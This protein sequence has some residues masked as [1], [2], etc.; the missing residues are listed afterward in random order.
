VNL[1]G[2]NDEFGQGYRLEKYS[3]D[4]AEDCHRSRHSYMKRETRQS[5]NR[6]RHHRHEPK[7]IHHE[8]FRPANPREYLPFDEYKP[9][10]ISDQARESSNNRRRAQTNVE[11][12][13]YIQNKSDDE[14]IRSSRTRERRGF[15][16]YLRP[17]L[18]QT[19][20]SALVTR[21]STDTDEPLIRRKHHHRHHSKSSKRYI[22]DR[23]TERNDDGSKYSHYSRD[24]SGDKRSKDV[25]Q[26]MRV[27]TEMDADTKAVIH[28]PHESDHELD[29][30]P[31]KTGLEISSKREKSAPLIENDKTR[32]YVEIRIPS[33]DGTQKT[34]MLPLSK[35]GPRNFEVDGKTFV[36]TPNQKVDPRGKKHHRSRSSKRL[37]SAMFR[38]WMTMDRPTRRRASSS[39]SGSAGSNEQISVVNGPEGKFWTRKWSQ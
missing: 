25:Q 6:T 18:D 14:R 17:R 27:E 29:T 31:T 30:I 2:G 4:N 21:T 1:Y 33:K 8:H 9:R 39:N 12:V 26:D 13:R 19:E 37:P 38:N 15:W 7:D 28:I 10:R 32:E 5:P 23:S 16:D 35:S 36:I 34:F 22:S 11:T 20:S 24:K 3:P